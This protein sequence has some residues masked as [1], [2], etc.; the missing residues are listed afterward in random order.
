MSFLYLVLISI[1]AFFV[2]RIGYKSVNS[3]QVSS[4]VSSILFIVLYFVSYPTF[5]LLSLHFIF[6]GLCLIFLIISYYEILNLE[7][8]IIEE[9]QLGYVPWQNN[10]YEELLKKYSEEE[11]NLTG[12]YYK[13]DKNGKFTD[14]F[15]SRVTFPVNNITGDTIAFGGRIIRESK[16]AK[17]INS[18]ETEFYKKGS[19][20]FNLDKAKDLRSETDNV[21]IVEGYMDV[22]SLYAS[23]IKNVIS[24]SGTALT[25]RQIELIWKFFSNPIICLDGDESG[26]KAALRIAEKL[27]PLINEKNK[28]YFSVMPDGKDPDDFIRQNGKNGLLE[29]L[30]KKLV[31]RKK[32]YINWDP[33]DKTVLANEQVVD[34]KG[35]RSGAIVE[36][37]KLNQWFFK[38]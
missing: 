17:Y 14:R 25:E 2:V 6:T 29:L 3:F 8:K 30:K 20:I 5:S 31:Y 9:F 4:I 15:N 36:R 33:V 35:W 21:L 7:K 18:P 19:M 27:F 12:L 10:F 16:L 34:G 32:N 38:I 24:N 1:S 11:I 28:I 37:K 23:G 26:Q 22:V 13:N